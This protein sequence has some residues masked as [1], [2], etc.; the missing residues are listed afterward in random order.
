[1]LMKRAR[2]YSSSCSLVIL[3]YLYPFRRNSLFCSWKS[4]KK[5]KKLSFQGSRAFKVINVDTIKKHVIGACYD[6]QHVRACLQ[7]FSR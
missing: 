3:V 7:P 6:K 2:A 5:T 1:M 4:Q